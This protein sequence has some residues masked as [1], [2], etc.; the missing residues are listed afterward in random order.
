V[1][2]RDT[3]LQDIGHGR[4][5]EPGHPLARLPERHTC[6]GTTDYTVGADFFYQRSTEVVS[7]GE[8]CSRRFP[9]NL[10]CSDSQSI[11]TS[12]RGRPTLAR[13]V[14]VLRGP[15]RWSSSETEFGDRFHAI[16]AKDRGWIY[17]KEESSARLGTVG[18]LLLDPVSS[19]TFR[20]QGLRSVRPGCRAR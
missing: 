9:R 4:V 10:A 15:S 8:R 14:E 3:L 19:A 13:S 18:S 11:V 12:P 1:R 6:L 5:L 17:R 7:T 2:E 16:L 20:H